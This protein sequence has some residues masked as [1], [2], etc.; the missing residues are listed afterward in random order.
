MIDSSNLTAENRAMSVLDIGKHYQIIIDVSEH[1]GWIG[2][3]VQ[4]WPLADS[5][6][7]TAVAYSSQFFSAAFFPQLKADDQR[8]PPPDAHVVLVKHCWQGLLHSTPFMFLISDV[9]CVGL[10]YGLERAQ[11]QITHRKEKR[12]FEPISASRLLFKLPAAVLPLFCRRKR[13]PVCG[14]DFGNISKS[15]RKSLSRCVKVSGWQQK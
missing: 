9:R 1:P 6:E 15:P 11:S 8:D 12:S 2:S 5:A 10:H 7:M 4:G 3:H 14:R 13:W